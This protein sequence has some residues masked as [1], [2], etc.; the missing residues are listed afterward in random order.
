MNIFND[1]FWTFLYPARQ[2]ADM[3][4]VLVL[5]D[6][7]PD[8]VLRGDVVPRFGQAVQLLD[9]AE[10][11]LGGSAAITA[12]ALARLGRRTR[13]AAAVGPDLFGRAI[14]HLLRAGGVDTA[15][16][17]V[18]EELCT[19][20]TV[21][22]S[23]GHDRAI[24]THLGAISSL[25]A[26]QAEH[27][28]AAAARDGARHLHVSSYFLLGRLAVALPYLLATA[29]SHGLTT[30]LD[31]NNDPSGQWNGLAEVLPDLDYF[32]PNCDETLAVAARLTGESRDDVRWAATT[33]ARYGPTVV[34]K[35]GPR[36]ALRV[37]PNGSVLSE[38]GTPVGAVDTT[39]ASDTFNAAYLDSV[40]R[41]LG[42]HECLRRATRAGALSTQAVGGIAGQ[43]TLQQLLPN[44]EG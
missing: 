7:N 23:R 20:L 37:E 42:Q 9:S 15:A 27:Q 26:G 6:V 17:L 38:S 1:C 43:P 36:G 40:L 44:T 11:V 5:G 22:L 24:L 29:H 3:I 21:I 30:S 39:G 19:G 33:I 18:S 31:T 12:H 41:G 34:V 13:L 10:L 32:L 35:D 25:S 2:T 28:L 8:L 14:L 4:D 16:V